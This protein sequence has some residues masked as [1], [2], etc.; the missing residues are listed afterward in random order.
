MKKGNKLSK[1]KVA[2]AVNV[3]IFTIEDNKL[4]LLMVERDEAPFKGCLSLPEFMVEEDESLDDAAQRGIVEETGLDDLFYEQIYTFGDVDRDP[5]GR[6]IS[7]AYL[8]L[9]PSEKLVEKAKDRD[10]G[11]WLV[12]VDDLLA[13]DDEIAFDYREVIDYARFCLKNEAENT[14][15][16]FYLLDELFTLPELQKTYEI[17]MDKPLYKANFRKKIVGLVEET[18]YMTAGDAH[19]PSRLYKLR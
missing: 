17:L 11:A 4:Q 10:T 6:I 7:V 9:A 18:E 2:V 16:A 13:G 12:D 3:L 1:D 19:R 5:R 15:I 8:A 14:R